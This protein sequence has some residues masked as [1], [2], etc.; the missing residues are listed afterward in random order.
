MVNLIEIGKVTDELHKA[1]GELDQLDAKI[2]VINFMLR[3]AHTKRQKARSKHQ[4]ANIKR[5]NAITEYKKAMVKYTEAIEEC[6]CLKSDLG[7]VKD[8][9]KE[10]IIKV[11]SM[12]AQFLTNQHKDQVEMSKNI[13]TELLQAT[14]KRDRLDDEIAKIN[15]NDNH[16]CATLH[17]LDAEVKSLQ[18]MRNDLDDIINLL[19]LR[20]LDVIAH[21]YN[22]EYK[23]LNEILIDKIKCEKDLGR[24]LQVLINARDWLDKKI[25]INDDTNIKKANGLFD[26]NAVRILDTERKHLWR[27]H[28]GLDRMVTITR[29][30]HDAS[31][32][33]VNLVK[34]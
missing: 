2:N 27:M 29:S 26:R 19:E 5:R 30:K 13:N 28:N 8:K 9:R 31:G 6:N 21:Q 24:Q 1:T 22:L 12:N 32:E 4:K 23:M 15:L 33:S 20:Y 18:V 25:A 11:T 17:I 10:V 14:K 3:D 16:D 7:K 34:S